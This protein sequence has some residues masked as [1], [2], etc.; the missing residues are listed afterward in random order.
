MSEQIDPAEAAR[1]LG[2]IGRWREQVIRRKVFPRW[3]WWT[4]AVLRT[5]FSTAVESAHGVLL[6]IA[7]A[8][9]LVGMLLVDVPVRRAARAAAARR[10]LGARR[11]LIGLAVFVLGLLGVAM[12]TGFSL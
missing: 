2:E 11:T 3:W 1:A 4:Y 6:G 8:L 10:G 9:F 12:A 7:I 5:A